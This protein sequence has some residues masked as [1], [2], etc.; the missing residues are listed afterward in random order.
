MESRG[1]GP[2]LVW[3]VDSMTVLL[4][5]MDMVE[6]SPEIP[7][8]VTM[9]PEGVVNSKTTA[10]SS[11]MAFFFYIWNPRIARGTNWFFGGMGRRGFCAC[12]DRDFFCG[13]LKAVT[14]LSSHRNVGTGCSP[15]L[16]LAEQAVES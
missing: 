9:C 16:V 11:F 5:S 8:P 7:F 12:K 14:R 1:A 3:E 15:L 2:L 6:T 10:N 13:G 4:Q